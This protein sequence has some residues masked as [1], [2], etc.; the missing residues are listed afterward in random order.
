[1][2]L[3]WFMVGRSQF[4]FYMLPAVP[5][6]CLGVVAILHGLPRRSDGQLAI[7]VAAVVGVVAIAYLARVD[8]VVDARGLAH[9]LQLASRGGR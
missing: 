7:A 5:F 6:M 8:R 2:F 1:M 3:P 4:L 9:S